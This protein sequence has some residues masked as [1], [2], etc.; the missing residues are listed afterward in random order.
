VAETW[1]CIK[2]PEGGIGYLQPWTAQRSSRLCK[3]N[4]AGTKWDAYRKRGYRVVKLRVYE[5]H[6]GEGK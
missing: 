4:F 2:A 1:W 5:E 6:D 3:A